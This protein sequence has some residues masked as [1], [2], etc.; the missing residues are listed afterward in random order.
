MAGFATIDLLVPGNA[1]GI[2]IR[3]MSAFLAADPEIATATWRTQVRSVADPKILILDLSSSDGS[4]GLVGT[5]LTHRAPLAV[6]RSIEP[7]SYR[8]DGLYVTSSGRTMKW[9][10]GDFVVRAGVTLL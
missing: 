6:M 3:D 1:S 7:G 8:W 4:I 5:V 9:A 10:E 2:W